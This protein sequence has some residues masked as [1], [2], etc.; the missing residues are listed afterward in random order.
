MNKAAVPSGYVT[1]P[2]LAAPDIQIYYERFGRDGHAKPTVLFLH[3]GPGTADCMLLFSEHPYT[4]DELNLCY[5][6]N[7]AMWEHFDVNEFC[8]IDYRDQ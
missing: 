1:I 7:F 8:S 4:A 2:S 3:G 6:K 5:Q